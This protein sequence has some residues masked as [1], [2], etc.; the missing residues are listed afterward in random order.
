VQVLVVPPKMQIGF[1]VNTGDLAVPRSMATRIVELLPHT[2]YQALGLNFDYFVSQPAG[3]DFGSYDR[4]LLSTGEYSLLQEFTAQDARFGRYLSKNF[5]S[6]RLR[7]DIKPI[8]AGPQN[9]DM[10]YFSFNFHHDI[11]QV[12]QSDRPRELVRLIGTWDVL[13]AYSKKLTDMGSQPRS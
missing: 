13:R 9:S 5:G 2:P 12:E 7:L 3:R 8:K 10:L 1:P 4:E 11:G 6:A